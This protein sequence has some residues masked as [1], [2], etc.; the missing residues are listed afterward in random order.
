M[1]NVQ[2]TGLASCSLT[3]AYLPKRRLA[4]NGGVC[5]INK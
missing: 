5:A 2:L 4:S 1:E 3:Y